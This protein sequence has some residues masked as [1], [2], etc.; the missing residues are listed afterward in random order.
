MLRASYPWR[1]QTYLLAICFLG[2]T[3]L[4]WGAEDPVFS[5]PQAG[6]KLA[7]FKV[8]VLFGDLAGKEVDLIERAQGKPVLLIFSHRVKSA[9]EPEL[10]VYGPFP[11]TCLVDFVWGGGGTGKGTGVEFWPRLPTEVPRKQP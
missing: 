11:P 5:G 4:T 9:P 6:E 3:S 10:F 7:K 2:S 8:R 1:W